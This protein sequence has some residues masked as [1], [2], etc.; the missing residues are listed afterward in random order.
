MRLHA[1]ALALIIAVGAGASAS[2]A[3]PRATRPFFAVPTLTEIRDILAQLE[4]PIVS[5][6]VQRFSLPVDPSLYAIGDASALHKFLVGR[7]EAAQA[8]GRYDYGTLEYAYTL[9]VVAP[10]VASAADP[11]PP[12]RFHQDTFT[13]NANL[14]AFYT[15][16]LVPLLNTST[17][18]FFF[19]LSNTS[20]AP[21]AKDTDA[22][23]GVDVALL[24]LLSNRAHIGKVVAESKY[25]GNASLYTPLI[26]AQN[27]SA[28]R[29]LLT[30]TTQETQVLQQADAAAVALATAWTA[31]GELVP[32]TFETSVRSATAKVF[33]ELID[34]TTE[35][36]IEYL[37]QRL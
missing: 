7:E 33:R 25:A 11:F 28:I 21:D 18:G 29:T 12:G 22:A 14:T 5:T 35:I 2:H 23:L 3:R 30:N 20:S 37:L 26:H 17:T 13:G 1:A 27:S 8:L 36:E 24:Q 32:A 19:H 16:T 34:I 4:A 15:G 31:A 9:P 10:D 6:L